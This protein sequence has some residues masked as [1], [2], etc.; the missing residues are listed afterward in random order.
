MSGRVKL[1]RNGELLSPED[2]PPLGYEYDR[3]GEFDEQCGTFGLDEFQLPHPECP[4]AFVCDASEEM[5]PFASCID[6]MNCH[7]FAGMTT[8]VSSESDIALFI[9]Q[10]IPHHQNAVNMAKTLL[11]TD[12]VDCEELT[13]DEDPLCVMQVILREIINGQVSFSWTT[14][15]FESQF[16]Q[17]HNQ[18]QSYDFGFSFRTVSTQNFQIQ[19]MRGVLETL[20]LPATDD[21]EVPIAGLV[22]DD[23]VTIGRQDEAFPPEES[24]DEMMDP[25]P[26][27][28]GGFRGRN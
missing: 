5:Q 11:I 22:F 25:A 15:Q 6:A 23:T 24:E 12:S 18:N 2:E 20:D 26:D 27:S 8:G 9:H 16:F 4:S 14:T 19:A 17:G 13:D 7:M 1:M 3:P 28:R 10:M 21:C